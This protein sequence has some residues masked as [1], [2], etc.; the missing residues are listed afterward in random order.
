MSKNESILIDL[1]SNGRSDTYPSLQPS[2]GHRHASK[3]LRQ[4]QMVQLQAPRLTDGAPE[5]DPYA[6]AASK[7][8]FEAIEPHL[9]AQ[10]SQGVRSKL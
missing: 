8:L 2:A 9:T 10:H 4:L 5:I 3:H 1:A 7:D 6:A